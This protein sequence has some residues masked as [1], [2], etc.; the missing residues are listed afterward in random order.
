M[1][2]LT[3]KRGEINRLESRLCRPF[4][5]SICVALAA[6]RTSAGLNYCPACDA[7]RLQ[8]AVAPLPLPVVA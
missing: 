7:P 6:L 8:P 4:R 1:L 5:A 3:G 2:T